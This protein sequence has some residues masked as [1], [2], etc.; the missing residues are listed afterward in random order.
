MPD[1]TTNVMQK[2]HMHSISLQ[3]ASDLL[4]TAVDMGLI[5]VHKGSSDGAPFVLV[6][7]GTGGSIIAML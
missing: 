4:A 6:N 2:N 1:S 3:I 5:I 7:S